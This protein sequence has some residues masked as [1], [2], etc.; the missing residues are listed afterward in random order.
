MEF[1]LF[2][3]NPEKIIQ[4]LA[5]DRKGLGEVY[6]NVIQRNFY[7]GEAEIARKTLNDWER[8]GILP[9]TNKEKGWK[10]F[11]LIEFAWLK[12]VSELRSLGLP[13]KKIKEIKK[14]FFKIEIEEYKSLFLEALKTFE[15]ELAD[16]DEVI[17]VFKRSDLPEKIWLETMEE[18]QVSLFTMLILEVLVNDHNLCFTID[19]ENKIQVVVLGIAVDDRVKKNEAAFSQLMD[20]SFVLVN[21]RKIIKSFFSSEKVKY[22][23]DYIISFLNPKEKKIIEMIQKGGIKEIAI[24]F[25]KNNEPTHIELKNAG[26]TDEVIKKVARLIKK[27]EYSTITVKNQ[28]GK[29]VSYEK[30]NLIKL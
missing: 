9:F 30:N 7:I 11:S 13:I 28:D 22:D 6:N 16:K 24:R 23:T 4:L 3:I 26:I 18:L 8:E 2:N 15:G 27:G 20:S 12:C 1:L 29:V 10:Q 19:N 17:E 14:F 21:L 5:K 25:G